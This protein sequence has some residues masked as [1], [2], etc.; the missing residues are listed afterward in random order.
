MGKR[1]IRNGQFRFVKIGKC[2]TLENE[3]DE[4]FIIRIRTT[5]AER[6]LKKHLY[7]CKVANEMVNTER[8]YMRAIGIVLSVYRK[9]AGKCLPQGDVNAIFSNLDSLR[10][11]NV[12]FWKDLETRVREW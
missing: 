5:R 2:L 7:R 11:L 9:A 12:P 3:F 10:T 6:M 4:C 8:G 1:R